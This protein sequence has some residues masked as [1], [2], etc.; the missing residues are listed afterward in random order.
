MANFSWSLQDPREDSAFC[1]LVPDA[2][3]HV[4]VQSLRIEEEPRLEFARGFPK[5]DQPIVSM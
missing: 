4:Y 5:W 3:A 2:L 1:L